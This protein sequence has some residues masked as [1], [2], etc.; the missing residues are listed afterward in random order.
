MLLPCIRRIGR[1]CEPFKHGHVLPPLPQTIAAAHTHLFK[2]TRRIRQQVGLSFSTAATISAGWAPLCWMLPGFAR[3]FMG[4]TAHW[5]S[6]DSASTERFL[7]MD[8]QYIYLC[9]AISV[10]APQTNW[11]NG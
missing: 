2:C 4:R 9:T 8:Q 10:T 7:S 1:A 5:D 11:T 6:K 3:I